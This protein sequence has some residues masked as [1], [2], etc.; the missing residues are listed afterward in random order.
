MIDAARFF[1]DP[2]DPKRSLQ[3]N[4]RFWKNETFHYL[5]LLREADDDINNRRFGALKKSLKPIKAL[6]PPEY[7]RI[8]V[9]KLVY[10]L[11]FSTAFEPI[12]FKLKVS[13]DLINANTYTGSETAMS[14]PA[15][16]TDEFRYVAD[17]ARTI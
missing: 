15:R 6:L 17:L 11:M 10:S 16:M 4:N 1:N 3:L 5:D 7:H 9:A 8:F 14:Q 12:R 13:D 2:L